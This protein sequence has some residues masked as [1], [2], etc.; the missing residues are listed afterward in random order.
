MH[1]AQRSKGLID[2]L[3]CFSHHRLG[4]TVNPKKKIWKLIC[5]QGT[6]SEE[7]FA[8]FLVSDFIYDIKITFLVGFWHFF[9]FFYSSLLIRLHKLRKCWSAKRTEY[10][11]T[12]EEKKNTQ[13]RQREKETNERTCLKYSS[14]AVLLRQLMNYL[15]LII[16][17]WITLK[18]IQK[19][20]SVSQLL[21]FSSIMAYDILSLCFW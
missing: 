19:K 3:H 15:W 2:V 20:H 16:S 17:L 12:R 21:R 6:H 11:Q 18:F 1:S 4:H 14:D 9:R 13:Y 5:V 7:L 8:T 10:F